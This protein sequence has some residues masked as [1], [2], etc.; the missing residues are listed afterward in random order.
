[1]RELVEQEQVLAI[2]GMIGTPTS[3]S[4]QR[5]LNESKVPQLFIQ[6]GAPRFADPKQYPWTMPIAPGY[7]DEARVYARY[8]LETKP[9]AKIGMLYQND[10]SGKAYSAGFKEGLGDRAAK[11]I[12]MEAAYE[13]TDPTVDSQIVSLRA[14]GADVLFTAAIPKTA[15]QAIR[16]VHDIG[17]K[18]LHFMYFGGR[19]IPTVL[20]PAGLE[21]SVGL[22]SAV[23]D[24]TPGDPHWEHDP[25]YQTYLAFMKQYYSAGDPNDVLNFTAYSWAYTLGQVL[26]QCGDDLTRENLMFQA[27]HLKNFNAPGLLPGITLNTSPTDY[28][29]IK[30]FIL[31]RFDG[32]QWVPISKIIEVS[33][34]D[35]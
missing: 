26:E 21:K 6:S 12:V 19:S 20:K 33:A 18:P 23:W 28:R 14:S 1:M 15:A 17:W 30:Q 25:D 27:S 13:A 2:F 22:I 8:I 10:D 9:E 29:P 5:Y 24:M 35:Y 16:K 4:V 31:H 32:Q 3:A 7:D 34:T 11:M